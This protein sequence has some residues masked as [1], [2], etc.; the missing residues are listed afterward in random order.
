MTTN[1]QHQ[2]MKSDTDGK[3]IKPFF[4]DQQNK[5]K[6]LGES[7]CNCTNFTNV[8]NVFTVDHSGSSRPLLVFIDFTTK[9]ILSSDKHG[10]HCKIIVD[11]E[12]VRGDH[13][14][15]TLKSDSST[16]YWSAVKN[17]VLYILKRADTKFSIQNLLNTTDF[18]I[19][20]GHVQPYPPYKCLLPKHNKSFVANMKSRTSNSIT[21]LMPDY[22]IYSDCRNVSM[23]SVKYHVYY[24]PYNGEELQCD[25]SC[26]HM[27]TFERS[28][29]IKGLRPHSKYMFSIAISNYFLDL[30]RKP[31]IGPAVVYQTTPGGKFFNFL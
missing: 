5:S 27:E 12:I 17:D 18:L 30:R 15:Q 21:L 16:V 24:M 23:A 14:L 29:E 10:C 22:R 8:E 31:H 2:L 19:F 6:S 11:K 7:H 3:N 9:N 20:G 26:V 25:E 28:L 4:Y 1:P 13:P